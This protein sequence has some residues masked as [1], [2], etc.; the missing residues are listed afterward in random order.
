MAAP[1]LT[2]FLMQTIPLANDERGHAGPVVRG[3]EQD[4]VQALADVIG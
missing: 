1:I 3:N 4:E 2:L